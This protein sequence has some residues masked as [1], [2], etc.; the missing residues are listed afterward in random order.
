VLQAPFLI[1]T[2]NIRILWSWI[3]DATCM[4][5]FSTSLAWFYTTDV[6]TVVVGWKS[7][8]RWPGV[9]LCAHAKDY[10]E[11]C[12][13]PPTRTTGHALFAEG[14]K[15]KDRKGDQR[16]GKWEPQIFF[17]EYLAAVSKSPPNTINL[18]R[19]KYSSQLVRRVSRT[20]PWDGKKSTQQTEHNSELKR[21]NLTQNKKS[22]LEKLDRKT[23]RNRSS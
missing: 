9:G 22:S 4:T 16:R 21:P 12:S 2:Q 7:L 11:C 18:P 5:P 23:H 20:I 8:A 19:L 1:T 13:H 17:R 15:L 14:P 10:T 3:L 6:G